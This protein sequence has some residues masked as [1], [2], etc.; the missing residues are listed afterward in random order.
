MVWLPLKDKRDCVPPEAPC[1]YICLFLGTESP[2]KTL[3][4]DT[5][6][7]KFVQKG[8]KFGGCGASLGEAHIF[9]TGE[10]RRVHKSKQ[11]S[12]FF[13]EKILHRVSPKERLDC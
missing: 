8:A 1:R 4:L 7:L 6:L 2:A 9:F 3:G 10:M 13:Y 5:G 11:L 12:F